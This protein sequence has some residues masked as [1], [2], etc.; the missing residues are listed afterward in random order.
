MRQAVKIFEVIETLDRP[1]LARA[2][3]R[4]FKEEQLSCDLYIQINTGSEPQKAGILPEDA[5]EFIDVLP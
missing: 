5:D 1:K 4:I 3:A 2:L